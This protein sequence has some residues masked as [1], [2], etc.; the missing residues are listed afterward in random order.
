LTNRCELMGVR[1]D[2]L[3]IPLLHGAIEDVITM[4]Q[5]AIVANVNINAMNIAWEH[6]WFR[7]F[8]N[9]S[10]YVFCDGHGVMLG[11][12]FCGLRIPEKI[13]YAHWFPIFC[14]F[15][16]EKNFSLF[17]L[18]GAPGIAVEA[19]KRLEAQIPELRVVGTHDGFFDKG[20][21]SAQNQAVL[22]QINQA[23]PDVLLTSFGMPL[24]E[25]WLS[26]NWSDLSA[27]I[28]LTGGACLDYMAGR[29]NRPPDWMANHGLEWLG[30][31]LYEPGRLWKRYLIGNP[32]FYLR[33]LRWR[34]QG[35][36]G[37]GT[38]PGEQG[39]S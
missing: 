14:R 34:I 2:A 29:S 15:C 28:A 11:A 32:L 31:L 9:T 5:K 8:L 17:F 12:R 35:G 20:K 27:H 1:I 39:F 23:K 24:Q 37:A 30:R 13:T 18:G 38:T 21:K 36:C 22:A 25:K 6:S 33:L 10:R 3:T 16:A 7:D 19:R 26:E 4:R